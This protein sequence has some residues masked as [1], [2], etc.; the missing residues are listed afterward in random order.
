MD[1]K[2][3]EYIFVSETS[4]LTFSGSFIIVVAVIPISQID[5]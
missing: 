1:S 2:D 4:S 5:T 3:A